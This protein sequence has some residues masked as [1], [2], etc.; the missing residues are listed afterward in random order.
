M[1][2]N[3]PGA[4]EGVAP[5]GGED[6]RLGTNPLAWGVPTGGDPM[7]LDMATSAASEGKIR[8]KSRRHEK[9]PD[10]WAI[11]VEGNPVTDAS[12][13]YGPPMG[14]ILSAG[15]K[16]YGFAL[17][18]DI[19]AGAITG[20]GCARPVDHLHTPINGFVVMAINVALFSA[21][22][23]FTAAVDGLFRYVKSSTPLHPGGR[24]LIPNELETN[25]RRR[26]LAEGIELDDETWQQI[27]EAARSV[28]IEVGFS[29]DQ[30]SHRK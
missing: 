25:E 27:V 16:G 3:A 14:A 18:V 29:T 2:C 22:S 30:N 21:F 19:L 28:G 6:D 7:V 17:V 26:R 11:N 8:V 13:F 5:W 10:G 15:H 12:D 23:E 9:L 24:V 1:C 4:G 20:G